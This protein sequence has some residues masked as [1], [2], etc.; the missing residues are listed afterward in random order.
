MDRGFADEAVV[1]VKLL[2]YEDMATYL[3]VKLADSD[4]KSR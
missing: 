1:A 3:R 2:A 4:M